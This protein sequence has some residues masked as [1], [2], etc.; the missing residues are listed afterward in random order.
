MA[1]PDDLY[2][3]KEASELKGISEDGVRIA[4]RAGRLIARKVNP[5]LYLI[6]GSDLNDWKPRKQRKKDD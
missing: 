6:Y 2:T 4:I 3:V 5:R 1:R